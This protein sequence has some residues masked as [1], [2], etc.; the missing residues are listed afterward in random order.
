VGVAQ[1]LLAA[2]CFVRDHYMP[3]LGG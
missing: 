3:T 2:E 1:E